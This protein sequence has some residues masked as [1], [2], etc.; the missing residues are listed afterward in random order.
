M[1]LNNYTDK[2]WCCSVFLG[3]MLHVLAIGSAAWQP[4]ASSVAGAYNGLTDNS[5]TTYRRHLR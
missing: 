3:R 4:I 5:H 1:P 2:V